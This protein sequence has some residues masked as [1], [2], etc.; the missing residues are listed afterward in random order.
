MKLNKLLPPVMKSTLFCSQPFSLCTGLIS[1]RKS[2]VWQAWGIL[3]SRWNGT[4]QGVWK[5]AGRFHGCWSFSATGAKVTVS[6][7]LEANVVLCCDPKVSGLQLL[8]SLGLG[9]SHIAV[10][11][12]VLTVATRLILRGSCFALG[13]IQQQMIVLT[14]IFPKYLL[15]WSE[16]PLC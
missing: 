8:S 16:R 5:M 3:F 14:I 4:L 6:Y 13:L 9:V 11:V 1:V 15:G 10:P 2:E 7:K 12:V